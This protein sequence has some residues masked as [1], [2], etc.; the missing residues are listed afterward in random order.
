MKARL[1]KV[2]IAL[3][4][5]VF[6]LGCQDMGPGPVGPEGLGPEFVKKGVDC[7][8][9]NP[10]PSCPGGGNDD[11]GV[12]GTVDLFN[13]PGGLDEG[14]TCGGGAKIV[15]DMVGQVSWENVRRQDNHTH[16][17]VQLSGV[18]PGRYDIT[19]N[20]HVL[21]NPPIE[22]I[23]FGLRPAH[24]RKVIVDLTGID[25]ARIG[26]TFGSESQ[27]AVGHAPG[28]HLV[29][30]TIR[31]PFIINDNPPGQGDPLPGAD[32]VVLRSSAF[33]MVIKKHKGH[34]EGG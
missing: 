20:Q 4:S 16:A 25:E 17:T 6:L 30:L 22:I 8:V 11:D 24:R 21:C 10:H 9:Q 29:W 7:S 33:G 12:G 27:I 28:T 34:H 5:T 31:G 32:Q 2:S 19:G 15:D 23:D 1:A 3:L 13:S 26:F 14:Y 18:V